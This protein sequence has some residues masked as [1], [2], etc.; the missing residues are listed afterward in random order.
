[1]S[2]GS[3]RTLSCQIP[4]VTFESADCHLS[5]GTSVPFRS[6]CRNVTSGVSSLHLAL[7]YI[8]QIAEGDKDDIKKLVLIP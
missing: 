4:P 5:D 2:L 7:C 1:M 3:L 6:R 8:G